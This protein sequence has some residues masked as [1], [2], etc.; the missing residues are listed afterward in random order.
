[1]ALRAAIACLKRERTM[2]GALGEPD[3]W[4]ATTLRDPTK[5]TRRRRLADAFFGGRLA[6]DVTPRG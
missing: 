1:L 4:N 2:L 5:Q 3:R 6:A